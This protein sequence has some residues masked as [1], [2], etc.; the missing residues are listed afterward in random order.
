MDRWVLYPNEID[1]DSGTV[2]EANFIAASPYKVENAVYSNG[3]MLFYVQDGAVY[4][5]GGNFV[6][7]FG[8]DYTMLKEIAVAPLPG[9]CDTWCL[10]WLEA[11]P[12]TTLE[13]HFQEVKVVDGA[14][15][16]GSGGLINEGE[17]FGS[18][19]GIAVSKPDDNGERM[20][21]LVHYQGIWKYRL[22]SNGLFLE[23]M[24]PSLEGFEWIAEADLSP[25][26]DFLAWGD[27][28]RVC[29]Y[30]LALEQFYIHSL[31]TS[32]SFI[33]GLE[34]SAD[35]EYL[36]ICHSEK[37]LFRWKFNQTDS[38]PEP[39]EGSKNFVNTQ[40]ELGKDGYIYAVRK[41]GILGI[42]GDSG[43]AISPLD[44]T[45]G[46]SLA[47]PNW[48][49]LFALPDQIDGEVYGSFL[50]IPTP[51]I[52]KFYINGVTVWEVIDEMHPP[53]LVYNCT[54]ILLNDSVSGAYSGYTI[55]VYQTDPSSGQQIT[56]PGFLDASFHFADTP[57]PSI[58]IRC[59]NDSINCDLFDN[60]INPPYN[61][62]AVALLLEGRCE[63]VERIGHIEVQDAPAA[64]DIGLEINDTQTGIPCPAAHDIAQA[65]N[66][67]IYS[68][69]INLANSNGDITFYQLAIDEVSCENGSTINNIFTGNP[70]SVN[71]VAGLTA[72]A[73]NA[74][75]INGTTGYFADPSWV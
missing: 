13:F 3:E 68:A 39:V 6:F 17:L 54:P 52:E 42:I 72:I 26:G 40:L 16:P 43:V 7:S 8:Y 70:V 65:C 24:I 75:Q 61:T 58:D 69:S 50:G 12:L 1:F 21:Y 37:G 74:L 48:D 20:I 2:S 31:G 27:D 47:D 51:A 25:N 5:S 18:T 45:V 34:F 60:Y 33:F 9:S 57:P 46:S 56:G 4:D 59:L 71:G 63:S 44:V 19:G 55:H 28:N 11:Y 22:Q 73:L 10:F 66:S 36:Y 53:L 32:L 64:A 29:V 35:N 49:Q 62:F 38:A 15:V 67:G 30:N 14:I 41:D 23:E